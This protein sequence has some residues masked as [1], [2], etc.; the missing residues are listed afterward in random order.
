M[1]EQEGH[2]GYVK[3]EIVDYGY[4]PEADAASAVTAVEERPKVR[5]LGS[6]RDLTE[7][8]DVRGPEEGKLGGQ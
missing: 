8:I 5:D 2:M 4:L 6:L 1:A 3:P 7:S